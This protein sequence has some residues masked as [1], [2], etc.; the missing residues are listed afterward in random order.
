MLVWSMA[1]I[2]GVASLQANQEPSKPRDAEKR[3]PASRKEG[4]ES[5]P[6]RPGIQLGQGNYRSGSASSPP[7]TPLPSLF[8][9]GYLDHA[10]LTTALRRVARETPDRVRLESLASTIKGH[11]VWLVTLSNRSQTAGHPPSPAARTTS[12]ESP[13]PAILIVANLEGDHVIGSQVALGLIEHIT[14]DA[15]WGERLK[16]C[17]IFV[18]P[19]LNPDGADQLLHSPRVEMR[20]NLQPLD[21]DR[22]GR[23]GE[24]GSDDLNGDGIVVRM[25]VKDGKA[26][27]LPDPTTRGFFTRPI[28]P[29][30]SVRFIRSMQ[31]ASTMMGTASLMKMPRAE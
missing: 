16:R 21:R 1:L 3:E 28:L 9:E 26:T 29:R 24:D 30:E 5:T 22:D 17:T 6:H 7:E 13:S 8:P 15:A 2:L 25:R 11:E 18:V 14:R 20:T 10:A 12:L 23:S 4:Q 31:R 27:L 19:R